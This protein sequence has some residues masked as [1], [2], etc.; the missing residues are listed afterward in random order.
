MRRPRAIAA[1]TTP[2]QQFGIEVL[3]DIAP[4]TRN[5]QLA[6]G[7]AKEFEPESQYDDYR[8]VVLLII[9]QRR[10][11]TR[12]GRAR[13]RRSRRPSTSMGHKGGDPS[14]SSPWRCSACGSTAFDGATLLIPFASTLPR[15][16]R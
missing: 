13:V 14:G 10:S 5:F 16:R 11:A 12:S 15:W 4:S 2:M 1:Y 9:F 8:H 7:V 6:T 3:L